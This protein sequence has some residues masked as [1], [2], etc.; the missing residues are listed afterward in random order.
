MSPFDKNAH[1][2]QKLLAYSILATIVLAI[3][4]IITGILSVSLHH[5]RRDVFVD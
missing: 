1:I 2:E 5:F 4:A 3:A